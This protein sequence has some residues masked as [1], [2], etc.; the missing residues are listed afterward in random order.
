MGKS[1]LLGQ[2]FG[3]GLQIF[4]EIERARLTKQLARLK[5]EEGKV[6]EAAEIL[7]EVAVV[8]QPVLALRHTHAHPS[9]RCKLSLPCYMPPDTIAAQNISKGGMQKPGET[10]VG[11]VLRPQPAARACFLCG[12]ASVARA[13]V[14][15]CGGRSK[16]S[17]AGSSPC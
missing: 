14:D 11:R 16:K 7:Q 17:K 2:R 6:D 10:T 4:V 8:S 3:A 9:S 15:V 5:E 12:G 1:F 13:H